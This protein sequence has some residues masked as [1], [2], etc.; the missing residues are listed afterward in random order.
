M[1]SVVIG[2]E[3]MEDLTQVTTTMDNGM[4]AL[5][6]EEVSMVVAMEDL[7]Q[8]TTTMDNGTEALITEVVSTVMVTEDL[9]QVIT[10]M[11]NGTEALITGE[12]SIVV[13]MEDLIQVTT[14]MVNGTEGLITGEVSIV[15]AMEDLTQVTT[16][17]DNGTVDSMVVAITMG[18]MGASMLETIT[19]EGRT[20]VKI[21][22]GNG[23]ARKVTDI[24]LD[25]ITA[26]REMNL[27]RR[28][29]GQTLVSSLVSLLDWLA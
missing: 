23:M 6:T 9:T 5:I 19:M 27:I 8:V 4:E 25:I 15:V 1:Q 22:T 18:R 24:I 17:M 26:T 14:T 21:T 12:A 13:A 2:V 3:I 11:D 10:T 7:T 28:M 29:A 16:I 20:R